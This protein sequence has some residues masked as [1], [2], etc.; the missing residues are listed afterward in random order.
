MKTHKITMESVEST[1]IHS[2]GYDAATQTLAVRFKNRRTLGPE[3]L[4]HY[5][6]VT[7]ADFEAL[8]DA[9]SIGSHLYR[10]I[11]PFKERFPYVCIEKAPEPDDAKEQP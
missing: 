7:Q 8:R 6:N 1:Q 3:A 2:I 5:S 10:H 11:K 4:Y 9:E